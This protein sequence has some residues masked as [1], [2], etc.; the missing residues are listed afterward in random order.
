M[1]DEKVIFEGDVMLERTTLHVV[2]EGVGSRELVI[3]HGGLDWDHSY[4]RPVLKGLRDSCCLTFF[5]LRGC[6]RSKCFEPTR[7]YRTKEVVEDMVQL[8]DALSLKDPILLGVAF[9]GRV[10]LEFIRAHADR[11]GGLVLVGA[12]AYVKKPFDVSVVKKRLAMRPV[13]A[14]TLRAMAFEGLSMDVISP[15]ALVRARALMEHVHFGAEWT[16]AALDGIVPYPTRTDDA[17]MLNQWG[18]PMLIL[19]GL[20]DETMPVAYARRLER[21]VAQAMLVVLDDAGHLSWLDR[22]DA[23]IEAVSSFVSSM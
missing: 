7:A 20:R 8:F 23:W 19:H 18:K 21:D 1:S 6:G 2:R 9:G 15:D 14:E 12:N 13:H 5:D 22:E 11:A 17:Q 16:R 10:A 3:I 4:L